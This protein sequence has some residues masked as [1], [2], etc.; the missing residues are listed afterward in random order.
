MIEFLRK[1]ES[2]DDKIARVNSIRI[3][4]VITFL[5][6]CTVLGSVVITFLTP[7]VRSR[8]TEKSYDIILF[9]INY[10]TIIMITAQ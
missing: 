7:P 1:W 2:R 6:F 5:Q 8:F 4:K 9:L 10:Y 3:T